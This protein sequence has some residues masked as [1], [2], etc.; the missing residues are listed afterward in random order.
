MERG[1]G[2][3]HIVQKQQEL[4]L[5]HQSVA[6]A[7]LSAVAATLGR[8]PTRVALCFSFDE[9]FRGSARIPPPTIVRQQGWKHVRFENSTEGPRLKPGLKA[10]RRGAEVELDTEGAGTG[11][12]FSLGILKT[13]L[14]HANAELRCVPPCTCAAT[15]LES[16]TTA[17]TTTTWMSTP[18]EFDS[19][20]AQTCHVRI[21]LLSDKEPFKIVALQVY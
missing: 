18:I 13:R 19:P 10:W 20:A 11:R 9:G 12:C 4:R 17:I 16:W 1:P 15:S 5:L 14:S 8:R 7:A 3:N 2:Y 21:R 6:S